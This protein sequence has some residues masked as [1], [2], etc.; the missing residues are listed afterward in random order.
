MAH[1]QKLQ[2]TFEKWEA[3]LGEL[4]ESLQKPF[5]KDFEK[6]ILI[7][8]VTKRFEYTFE[9]MWKCLREKLLEEGVET[10]TPLACFKE[11][12][13]LKLISAEHEEVFPLMVRKRN[14]IVHIYSSDDAQE[15]YLMIKDIFYPAI[16]ILFANLARIRNI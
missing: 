13:Q 3:A 12:Y 7:E 8:I 16:Q 15:I 11:A 5:G 6:D 9:S 1:R 2:R 4:T 10:N 14:E